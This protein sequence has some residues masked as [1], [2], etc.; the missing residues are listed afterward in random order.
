MNGLLLFQIN[1]AEIL[2]IDLILLLFLT[3]ALYSISTVGG[4]IIFSSS[5]LSGSIV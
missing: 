3:M 1:S 4:T 2:L 5:I